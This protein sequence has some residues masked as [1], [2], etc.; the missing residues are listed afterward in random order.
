MNLYNLKSL[1]IVT[2]WSPVDCPWQ[3]RDISQ[4]PL[5]GQFGTLPPMTNKLYMG[6][7]IA[8]VAGA[9]FYASNGVAGESQPH[10]SSSSTVNSNAGSS[11]GGHHNPHP[12][13][14]QS[15]ASVHA[16]TQASA[17][18]AGASSTSTGTGQAAANA[19]G[20]GGTAAATANA[21]ATAHAAVNVTTQVVKVQPTKVI[22]TQTVVQT[23]PETTEPPEAEQPE[24]T[25]VPVAAQPA[26]VHIVAAQA[27]AA[28]PVTVLPATGNFAVSGALG[29]A[30]L[31]MAAWYFFRSKRT[32]LAAARK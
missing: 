23:A 27:V 14:T 19:K 24:Q 1:G 31:F 21:S 9:I 29:T 22:H 7:I 11:T 3:I 6:T 5:S 28:Q 15:R 32:L 16:H 30:A 4:S 13:G 8:L 2:D 20:K 26:Q 18:G 25:E 12:S 17:S 10:A